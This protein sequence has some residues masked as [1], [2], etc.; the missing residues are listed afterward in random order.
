MKTNLNAAQRKMEEELKKKI[1]KDYYNKL[2]KEF[3]QQRLP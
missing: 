2:Y 3:E 1:K